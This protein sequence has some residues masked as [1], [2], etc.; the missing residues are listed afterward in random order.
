MTVRL[1][2]RLRN[3]THAGLLAAALSAAGWSG[4]LAAPAAREVIG[5]AEAGRGGASVSWVLPADKPYLFVPAIGPNLKG[6]VASVEVGAEVGVVLFQRPYFAS[7]DLAC[8]L[9]LGLEGRA[10]LKWLGQV[11]R[12]EPRAALMPSETTAVPDPATGGYGSLIVYPRDLGPPPGVLL[13]HRRRTLGTMCPTAAYKTLYDRIFVPIAEPPEAR[14][15]FDLT[16]SHPGAGGKDIELSFSAAERLVFL[17][18]SN[19][20][21]RYDAVRHSFAAILFDAPGC[22]G[23]ALS[24]KSGP[25][26]TADL[27]LSDF[28]F[29][30]RARSVLIAYEAGALGPYLTRPARPEPA[31][32]ATTPVAPPAVAAPEAPVPTQPEAT[33]AAPVEPPT[34]AAP[35]AEAA[36]VAPAPPAAAAK[37][38]AP[39][40][41]SQVATTTTPAPTAPPKAAPEKPAQTAK[42]A[43][44][45]GPQP[46]AVQQA[47]PKIVP[48]LPPPP[49]QAP[50]PTVASESFR[51]PVQDIYR[52]NFC[53]H[54]KSDCGEPAAQAW[55][56]AKGFARA[57]AWK[58]DQN[59]GSLFPTIVMGD[60]RICAQFVC[61]GFL[62]ITCSK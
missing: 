35:A 54:W 14:R 34:P 32:V 16:G 36:P 11:G 51:Y 28:E 7:K 49:G 20:E 50:T 42:P 4:A 33:T 60:Q 53:L 22:R 10:D 40:P 9:D 38:A 59:I 62:E 43:P 1:G 15:C 30:N 29:R 57:S 45:P 18:P 48:K 39:E 13:M 55:C 37:A 25:N 17:L 21:T 26:A 2:P 58:I 61:D 56:R 27:R 5:Y 19:L 46:R 12:F 3:R 31:T 6:A 8:S 44:A 52:L 47:M 24:F 23:E 41:R